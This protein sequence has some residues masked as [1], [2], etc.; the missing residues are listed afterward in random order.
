MKYIHNYDC[1]INRIQ[2][3]NTQTDHEL[4]AGFELVIFVIKTKQQLQL[5][6]NKFCIWIEFLLIYFSLLF[7]SAIQK[8]NRSK[9]K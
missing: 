8:D 6:F 3:Y 7:V 5:V 4:L 2:K 1:Y 9:Y